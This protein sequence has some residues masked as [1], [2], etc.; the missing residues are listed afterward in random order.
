MTFPIGKR[1]ICL[2][3]PA[4]RLS[5]VPL[6]PWEHVEIDLDGGAQLDHVSQDPPIKDNWWPGTSVDSNDAVELGLVFC[7]EVDEG[8]PAGPEPTQHIFNVLL[9]GAAQWQAGVYLPSIEF[10][11]NDGSVTN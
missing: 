8:K 4:V 10:P 11:A 6:S 9:E 3:H 5:A 1:G 7:A 2:G